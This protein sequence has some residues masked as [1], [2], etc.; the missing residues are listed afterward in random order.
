[1]KVKT[2][3]AVLGVC[4][5]GMTNPALADPAVYRDGKMLIPTGATISANGQQYYKDVVLAADAAGKLQVV[6]ATPLPPVYV[7]SVIPV[8][9]END[10]LRS[11]KL[12][13]AGNKSVPCVQLQDAAVSYLNGVFTVLLA[14]SVQ[15]PAESCIAV[16][17]PFEITIE[18]DVT[19]L[20]AGTY[21]AIVNTKEV[22]FVLTKNP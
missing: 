15:G 17:D 1:M 6:S 2:L 11:V 18:L 13:I 16:L 12:T 22:S 14:E 20:P 9:T 21:K 19:T 8:V 5:A 10:D 3:M 7:D 4:L